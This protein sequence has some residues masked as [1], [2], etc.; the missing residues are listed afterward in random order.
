MSKLIWH[1]LLVCLRNYCNQEVEKDD[2]VHENIG[3][4]EEPSEVDYEVYIEGQLSRIIF[5]REP[6]CVVWDCNVAHRVSEGLNEDHR[7]IVN[8]WVIPFAWVFFWTNFQSQDGLSQ[9]EQGNPQ[10]HEYQEWNDFKDG[11]ED[12]LYQESKRL[13]EP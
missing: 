10:N 13:E 11:Q 6:V 2:E 1:Y 12:H 9:R 3:K 8:V 7:H 4:P 5:V